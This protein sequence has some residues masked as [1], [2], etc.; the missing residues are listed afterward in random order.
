MALVGMQFF[1]RHVD[2]FFGSLNGAFWEARI[3]LPNGRYQM[4]LSNH[5]PSLNDTDW[6]QIP[7]IARSNG[8]FNGATEHVGNRYVIGHDLIQVGNVSTMT[9]VKVV[10]TAAGGDIG[11][12]QYLIFYEFSS[13]DLICFWDHGSPVT[14]PN[15][16]MHTFFFNGSPDVG[17]IFTLRT[18]E[19]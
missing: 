12:F 8:Y 7:E 6:N 13:R 11:P 3:S 17:T 5:A 19:V 10:Q 1:D 15:G 4:A 16:G 9:G 18:Q 2:D 14:I